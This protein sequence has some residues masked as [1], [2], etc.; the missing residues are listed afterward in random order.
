MKCFAIAAIIAAI[1]SSAAATG[2]EVALADCFGPTNISYG[3]F[4]DPSMVP[5]PMQ[6]NEQQMRAAT[7]NPEIDPA[8]K[9][10]YRA[11]FAKRDQPIVVPTSCG[12]IYVNPRN[13]SDQMWVPKGQQPPAKA[14]GESLEPI[15]TPTP[16]DK[17][18]R[19]A[20][21]LSGNVGCRL[22]NM[23]CPP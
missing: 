6:I 18:K 13:L 22:F 20:R 5:K 4:I 8:V 23:D 15:P 10:E 2:I 9:A 12:T 17:T 3:L 1:T 11:A 19:S 21:E 7:L 16:N 14:G